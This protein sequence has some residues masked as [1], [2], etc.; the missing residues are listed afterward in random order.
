MHNSGSK[1]KPIP[2]FKL[3]LKPIPFLSIIILTIVAYFQVQLEPWPWG[4]R[5]LHIPSVGALE[6]D[7]L[8][9]WEPG[10]DETYQEIV[11][12]GLTGSFAG[13]EGRPGVEFYPEMGE[14]RVN[15]SDK[16]P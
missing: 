8:L 3:I 7:F 13:N 1:P 16:S 6:Q 9:R 11:F 12:N 14:Y 5:S 10:G 4:D 2:N 15:V